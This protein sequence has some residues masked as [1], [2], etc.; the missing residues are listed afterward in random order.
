MY[1]CLRMCVC[2]VCVHVCMCACV[3]MCCAC[4]CMC[5]ACVCMCCACVCMWEC[6]EVYQCAWLFTEA[7]VNFCQ[8]C[9]SDVVLVCYSDTEADHNHH[10]C[11]SCSL[12]ALLRFLGFRGRRIREAVPRHDQIFPVGKLLVVD[13]AGMQWETG[14]AVRDARV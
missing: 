7:C 9:A 2:G 6:A 3:C 14:A 1:A 5:C 4:V 11:I 13:A 8:C 10:V 12:L